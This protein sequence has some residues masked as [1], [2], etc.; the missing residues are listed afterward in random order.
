MGIGEGICGRYYVVM[1][2]FKREETRETTK[3]SLQKFKK[4]NFEKGKT[5]QNET[6]MLKDG[7]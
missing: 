1:N 6:K 7:V 4:K 2:T 3:V 5:N